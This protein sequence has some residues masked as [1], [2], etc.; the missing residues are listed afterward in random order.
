MRWKW[1]L[2][3]TIIVSLTALSVQGN[4]D[5]EEEKVVDVESVSDNPKEEEGDESYDDDNGD[6]NKDPVDDPSEDVNIEKAE[7]STNE[8]AVDV[9]AVSD[10]KKGRYYNYDDYLASALDASDSGYDWNSEY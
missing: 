4:D 5:D 8:D 9:G 7:E 10:K 6:E 1:L 2:V 3:I